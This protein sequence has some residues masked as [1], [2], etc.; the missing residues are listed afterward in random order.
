MLTFAKTKSVEIVVAMEL[1]AIGFRVGHLK[2]RAVRS[3]VTVGFAQ[4]T[5]TMVFGENSMDNFGVRTLDPVACA[6]AC[7]LAVKVSG[8]VESKT[9]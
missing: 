1:F 6:G 7:V 5:C 8:R 3:V 4:E 9:R 2:L